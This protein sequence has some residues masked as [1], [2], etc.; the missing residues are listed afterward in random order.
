MLSNRFNKEF[1]T[2]DCLDGVMPCS[3]SVSELTD[4]LLADWF[5]DE[6]RIFVKD[7]FCLITIV[8]EVVVWLLVGIL[9]LAGLIKF[10][11]VGPVELDRHCEL[12][13]LDSSCLAFWS[14]SWMVWISWAWRV[15]CTGWSVSNMRV[16]WA[17]II[18]IAE[19]WVD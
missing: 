4:R 6:P 5:D 16:G 17:I 9:K 7:V 10:K 2:C 14:V 15:F 8:G 12:I 19:L 3:C 18:Y 1:D 11:G 13:G